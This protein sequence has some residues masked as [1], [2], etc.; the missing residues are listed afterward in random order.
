MIYPLIGVFNSQEKTAFLKI[1]RGGDRRPGGGGAVTA[2]LRP[3]E[4]LQRINKRKSRL[5]RRMPAKLAEAQGDSEGNE[6]NLIFEKFSANMPPRICFGKV[7]L[8][9]TE[10]GRKVKHNY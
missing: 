1:E 10:P 5:F 6:E 8:F 4:P 9:G 2:L 3:P 7:K